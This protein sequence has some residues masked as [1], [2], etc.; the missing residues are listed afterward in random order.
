[1]INRLCKHFSHKINAVWNENQGFIEFEMGFCQLDAQGEL[2][3]FQC[4]AKTESELTEI[5]DCM[6]SHFIRFAKQADESVRPL[7]MWRVT[8][9]KE[10]NQND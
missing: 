3:V 1:M 6:D 8:H 4:G 9:T 10:G 2:L 7:L 5:T